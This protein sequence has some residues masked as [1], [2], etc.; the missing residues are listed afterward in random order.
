M[1][2]GYK[3]DAPMELNCYYLLFRFMAIIVPLYTKI[4]ML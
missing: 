2:I 3:Q 4:Q 1:F